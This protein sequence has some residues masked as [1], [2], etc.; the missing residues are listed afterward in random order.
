MQETLPL[1]NYNQ[2][3]PIPSEVAQ[4]VG[5]RCED[6]VVT[7]RFMAAEMPDWGEPTR[8]VRL[9]RKLAEQLSRLLADE[10]QD[11]E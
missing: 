7:L 9:D 10:L 3:R 5:L 4:V 11:Y 8:Q 6:Q 2:S 1:R